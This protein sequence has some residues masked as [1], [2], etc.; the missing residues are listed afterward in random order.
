MF[1]QFL[2]HVD[3]LHWQR[4][5]WRD[6][7]T[8]PIQGYVALTVT[9]GTTCA[10]YLAMKAMIQLAKDGQNSH[11]M[12]HLMLLNQIYVDDIFLGADDEGQAKE[13]R[14]QLINL[15]ATAGMQLGKWSRNYPKLLHGLP[16]EDVFD[17]P[18]PSG[19]IFSTLELKWDTGADAFLFGTVLPSLS[20]LISK[21]TVP[22]DT[23]RLFD[24]LGF[25]TPILPLDK[26]A[27]LERALA[28]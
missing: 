14:D 26:A 10:P 12:A 25:I 6:S 8:A 17:L 18:S 9:Y 3:D 20:S 19:D 1:R 7:I 4:L 11:P 13:Q 27:G 15:L 21:R 28:P 22:S 23:A 2:V 16:G 24:A 5:V